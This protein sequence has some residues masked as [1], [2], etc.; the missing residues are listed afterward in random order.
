MTLHARTNNWDNVHKFQTLTTPACYTY[1]KYR[2]ANAAGIH[3]MNT[4]NAL[5]SFMSSNAAVHPSDKPAT[6]DDVKEW[7]ASL[8]LL[9]ASSS[10]ARYGLRLRPRYSNRCTM[11]PRNPHRYV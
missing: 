10:F 3:I 7:T 9:I 4:V 2:Y 11:F 1:N 8:I 6:G 5:F